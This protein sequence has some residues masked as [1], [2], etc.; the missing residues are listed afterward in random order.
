MAKKVKEVRVRLAPS[1]TGVLHLGT[2]RTA[3]FN[4]LF[5]KKNKGKF[6]LRIEDTDFERS[7]SEYE[8]EILQE[9]KWL[10]I[11]W[12]EG[13][14][15]SGPFEPYRQSERIEIYKKYLEKLIGEKKAYY[16]F[17]SPEELEEMKNYH[18]SL[19][20]APK[21]SGKCAD[22]PEKEAKKLIAEGKP[23]VIR[24]RVPEGKIS[25]KDL[26]RGKI[27]FDG[28]LFGDIVIAKNLLQPL[29]NFAVVVDDYEMKISHI[30]R[31]EEHISN[32]P[33]Q[34]L[35]QKALGFNEIQYAH[36]PLIL[37]SDR[38]KL[39]KRHGATA[40]SS[41]RKDGYLPEAICNFL[42]LLGWNPGDD[43][44]IFSLKS[45]IKEFSLEKVQKSGA[46][47]N[48]TRL[49]WINGFYIR[50]K[51]L[52]DLVELIL[53]YW[54]NAGIIR[55]TDFKNK[56]LCPETN[57]IIDNNYLKIIIQTYQT[58]IKKLSEIVSETDFFFK[59]IEY[60]K[61]LLKWKENSFEET[62]QQIN[63]L[64]KILSGIDDKDWNREE[65]EKI[66][67]KEANKL[68]DRGLMLWPLRVALTGKKGSAGPIEISS[69]LGK[70]KTI[71]RLEKASEK[72]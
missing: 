10:G 37:G 61:D 23:Y 41:F 42:A 30:I 4:Y 70:Q 69:I 43:R 68:A 45:L 8:K 3:L 24:F 51:K 19:G 17:C 44:E 12:N 64:I 39:S 59:E 21:Y 20:K 55:E 65:I 1:P 47:F 22:L 40:V 48:S 32:T 5:A 57:E 31:G 6:I 11:E 71:E 63:N 66:T 16:C 2:A 9:L 15:I 36:I 56:Y 60:E 33:R 58:R 54:L 46:V 13:P 7:K 62:K 26:I 35:I 27:E 25:F 53:P 50:N 38:S 28:T 72:I 34:I 52:S 14:D 49:D 18:Q 29:Y 67:L